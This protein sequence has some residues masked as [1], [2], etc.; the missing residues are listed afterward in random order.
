ML[1]DQAG[2]TLEQVAQRAG[3]AAGEST[4]SRIERGVVIPRPDT[5]RAVLA[6]YNLDA[7]TVADVMRMAAAAQQPPSW[8]PYSSVVAKWFGRYLDL[9]G[10][11]DELSA[12]DPTTINGLVQ[13]PAYA[14]AV[15]LATRPDTP[16]EQIQQ[17]VELRQQRQ[18]RLLSGELAL[19]LVLSDDVLGRTYGG[20][21][22]H[23]GQLEHLL[24]LAGTQH[25]RVSIQLL[26][27][28]RPPAITGPYHLIDFPNPV[29]SS[30]VYLETEVGALYLDELD[31][32][33]R[34]ARIHGTLRAAARSPE[35]SAAIIAQ[36]LEEMSD[37]TQE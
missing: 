34:Y 18:Q 36:R 28:A 12:Y 16:C 4:I 31:E 19:S 11:A 15:I 17:E 26:P 10:E 22:V 3:T 32:V 5:L 14:R 23:R 20:P 7:D 33:R 13:T 9:E 35:D 8:I 21:Q 25:R 1:R 37:A 29:D 2:L 6:V 30:V 27:A 24:E